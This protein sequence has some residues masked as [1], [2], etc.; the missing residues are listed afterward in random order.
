V[1]AGVLRGAAWPPF[2]IV[3]ILVGLLLFIN[4]FPDM[5]ADRE[6]G[7]RHI[8]IMLGRE[9]A[10]NLYTIIVA[11]NYLLIV[12]FSL[13]GLLPITCLLSLVSLPF[14]YRASKG[15]L[16]SKGK[17]PEVIPAMANNLLMVL[18]TIAALGVGLLLGVL[19]KLPL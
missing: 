2:I 11:V 9:R 14:G 4:E 19:L 12:L 18:I 5:E 8:V 6:A 13:T 1:E 7:R 3:S 10:S 16:R 15:L 17:I